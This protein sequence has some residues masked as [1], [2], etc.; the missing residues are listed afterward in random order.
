MLTAILSERG[1][2]KV[3]QTE[4]KKQLDTVLDAYYLSDDTKLNS[5]YVKNKLKDIHDVRISRRQCFLIY[6]K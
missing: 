3:I 5:Q 4:F 6:K 1:I 2:F